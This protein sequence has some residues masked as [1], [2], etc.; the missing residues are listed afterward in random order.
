MKWRLGLDM[1][2]GSIG[3]AAVRLANKT[4]T[5]LMDMGVRV[6]PDG[7]EPAETAE[8]ATL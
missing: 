7:R 4:P 6:F 5:E 2:T 1:G 8:Q 3:W